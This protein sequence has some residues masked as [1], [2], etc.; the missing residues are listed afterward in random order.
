MFAYAVEVASARQWREINDA[1]GNLWST[2]RY[3]IELK[4]GLQKVQKKV[5][6]GAASGSYIQGFFDDYREIPDDYVVQADTK[7]LVKRYAMP[8][9]LRPYVPPWYD[10]GVEDARDNLE[11]KL[12]AVDAKLDA[13]FESDDE[14]TRIRAVCK[15]DDAFY[16]AMSSVGIALRNVLESYS[17]N[18]L[19][20]PSSFQYKERIDGDV[21]SMIP[22][23]PEE[24]ECPACLEFGDHFRADC[25]KVKDVEAEAPVDRVKVLV[26]VPLMFQGVSK[27]SKIVTAEGEAVGIVKNMDEA[28]Q[29]I[30]ENPVQFAVCAEYVRQRDTTSA[31]ALFPFEA[32]LPLFMPVDDGKGLDFEPYLTQMEKRNQ[33]CVNA[34][35]KA[36]PALRHKGTQCQYFLKGRCAKGWLHCEFTHSMCAKVPVCLFYLEDKC[37]KGDKCEFEHPAVKNMALAQPTKTC[38]LAPTKAKREAVMEKVK[39]KRRKL[40]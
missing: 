13:A 31:N 25:L 27:T 12:S 15:H 40:V 28:L 23:P 8:P 10:A 21:I 29:K 14:L 4:V 9:A 30:Q 38:G 19:A 11:D 26:G 2:V 7:I 1:P 5:G 35:Y 24:Y 34:F 17:K 22:V 3:M 39:D 33:Q 36:N 16:A 20:H 37:K 32:Q 6:K 18:F